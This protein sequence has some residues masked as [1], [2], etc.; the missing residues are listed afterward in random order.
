MR[1][2]AGVMAALFAVSVYLQLN[3]PDPERW[4]AMYGAAAVVAALYALGRCPAWLAGLVTAV[5]LAWAAVWAPRVLGD[6]HVA[7]MF[8]S[9]RMVNGHA[10]EGRELGGL[11]AIVLTCGAIAVAAARRRRA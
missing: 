10:E 8:A 2:V 4:M 11:L 9:W 7:D 5:A 6:T 1:V 3:D